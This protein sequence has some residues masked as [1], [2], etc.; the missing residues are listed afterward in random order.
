MHY[1]FWLT[2][3]TLVAPMAPPVLLAVAVAQV[4]EIVQE[5]VAMSCCHGLFSEILGG[6]TLERLGSKH[7]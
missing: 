5:S 2:D 3:V 1:M 7:K 4:W 6:G